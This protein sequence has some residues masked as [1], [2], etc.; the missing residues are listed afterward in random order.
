MLL[1]YRGVF[2]SAERKHQPQETKFRP[3]I[4]RKEKT[5]P[6]LEQ[7]SFLKL[8]VAAWE[9]AEA[10]KRKFLYFLRKIRGQESRISLW[11]SKN[12][13]ERISTDERYQNPQAL[14]SMLQ[15]D[16]KTLF[17]ELLFYKTPTTPIHITG[18]DQ[19]YLDSMETY[20]EEFVESQQNKGQKTERAS[21]EENSMRKLVE[22]INSKPAE[23]STLI[24]ISP[25]GKKSEGYPG[26]DPKN[27]NMIYIY[28]VKN[29]QILFTQFKSWADSNELQ[30][31]QNQ[32]LKIGKTVPHAQRTTYNAQHKTDFS[33]IKNLITL[34]PE[35]NIDIEALIYANEQ[36]WPVNRTDFPDIDRESFENIRNQ[37]FEYYYLYAAEV[38]LSDVDP[39]N[40]KQLRQAIKELD[41]YFAST[42]ETLIKWVEDQTEGQKGFLDFARNDKARNAQRV[43]RNV[44]PLLNER[45]ALQQKALTGN[46]LSFKEVARLSQLSSIFSISNR[47]LSLAQCGVFSP[48][49]LGLKNINTLTGLN[50]QLSILSPEIKLQMLQN[51]EKQDYVE[52][53]LTHQGANKVWMVPK[54]YLETPGCYVGEDGEVYGP[55]DIP[56]NDPAETLALPMTKTEYETMI[57]QLQHNMAKQ[58][59]DDIDNHIKDNFATDSQNPKIQEEFSKLKEVV[60]KESQSLQ[61]FISNTTMTAEARLV[62]SRDD[63]LLLLS[64]ATASELLEELKNIISKRD[65]ISEV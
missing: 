39:D 49:S 62:L 54:S 63:Y 24:W 29:G 34:S 10:S 20:G 5:P 22:W 37:I 11:N 41:V 53:D 23:G 21:V 8:L 4:I 57:T 7:V 61:D 50:A 31:L 25:R 65:M 42:F 38:L 32:L 40:P 27:P 58:Q 1:Y 51:I 17:D 9:K 18:I 16:W 36:N 60:L 13:I 56:L 47:L 52:L 64:C 12:L 33:L 44:I 26:L 28:E 48:V 3:R 35:T 2:V 19:S 15:A 43:T 6:A 30:N 59:L 55:C 45:L 14:S 46:K